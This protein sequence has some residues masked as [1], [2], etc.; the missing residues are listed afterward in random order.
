MCKVKAQKKASNQ[1]CINQ[2]KC[3]G[4]SRALSL[5]N[6]LA[7]SRL[8]AKSYSLL[9]TI[10]RF[11]FPS[12]TCHYI[13]FSPIRHSSHSYFVSFVHSFLTHWSVHARWGRFWGFPRYYLINYVTT[14]VEDLFCRIVFAL[15]AAY[16]F[17]H[18]HSK[19]KCVLKKHRCH[20]LSE[21]KRHAASW[22]I[23]R[24]TCPFCMLFA[25]L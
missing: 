4:S 14:G 1:Q 3:S 9:H 7:F 20:C 23:Q 19:E 21:A 24:T 25:S 22:N 2:W 18:H 10:F 17:A 12:W 5:V 8:N 15:L 11:A 13:P 16:L 6:K